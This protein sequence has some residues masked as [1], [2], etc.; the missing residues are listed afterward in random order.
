[1]PWVDD[2]LD[3]LQVQI[4]KLWY[5]LLRLLAVAGWTLQKGLFMMGHAIE[6]ANI[7]LV[8]NAFAPLITQTNNQMRVTAGL[9]FVIALIVL[10]VTY[11]LAAFVKLDVVS[12]RGAIGWYLAGIV[13]FQLGPL[14][15]QGMNDFRRDLSTGF[16]TVALD[17]MQSA[18]SPFSSLGAVTSSDLPPLEACDA[19]GPYLPGATGFSNDVDGLDIALAYLLADG[20]DVMGYPPPTLTSCFQPRGALY[21]PALPT[22]WQFYEDSYF[23]VAS[24]SQFFGD[25]LGEEERK[26]SIDKAGAAQFR[27]FSAWPM[28]IFG[29][30]EQLIFLLLTIA[31]GLTFVSFSIA[32]LFAF[33]KKT[34]V[35]ARSILDMWI[36]LIVQTVVIALM[37][38]LIISF[39]LGAAATQNALVVLGV[40]L[41]CTIFILVLLWSGIKAVWNSFN[42]L[43]GAI[44]QATGGVMVAPGAMGLGL[45]GA[46]VAAGV[47]ATA[48]AVNVGSSALAGTTAVQRGATTSQTAGVMLGGSRGLQ[49][50]ART[51]A[52]LPGT[53][54]TP[55]GQMADE[56]T[57]GSV[58]RQVGQSIPVVGGIAGPVIGAWML[59][60]R[61]QPP[62]PKRSVSLP[63]E[64]SDT[65]DAETTETRP[66][67]SRRMGTFTPL[68]DNVPPPAVVRPPAAAVGDPGEEIE[69]RVSDVGASVR[70]HAG[71]TRA[72]VDRVQHSADTQGEEVEER[73]SAVGSDVRAQAGQT[74][75]DAE[76]TAYASDMHGEEVEERIATL[77]AT[78]QTGQTQQVMGLMRVEGADNVAG[79][80]GDFISQ[81]RAQRTLDDQPMTGG[82][83]HFKVAQGVARAMGVTPQTDDRAPIQGDVS[84]LGL[85]GD[86]ALRL[87]LNGQQAQTVITEVKNS[88]TGELAQPTRTMLVEQARGTLNTG[89][90][91]AERAVSALQRAAVMLPN[92]ITARG[93]AAVPNI[94]VTPNVQVQVNTPGPASGGSLD[95]SMKSQAG[96]A[97]SQIVPPRGEA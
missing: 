97:G 95:D 55:I 75:A 90:E 91:G 81:M 92:A 34:E 39:L 14:L 94:T 83:D 24:S 62:K 40:S 17:S 60:D 28:V 59:S 20:Q 8:E 46:G 66:A 23:Y 4:D 43:F 61:S 87:G 25:P 10:G 65:D 31:Q 7:W 69:E 76:R 86:M 44:G 58:L 35:I 22:H 85:F 21:D 79:V 51:L 42:R 48:A 67:R 1:M 41:L 50:A 5:D 33:F 15:Y 56:F 84:R 47:G 11:M 3:G 73:V 18:G 80:M 38:S 16:Y 9:A 13:F 19:L 32:I 37:Q 52:Y 6:L 89:W 71:Q 96:L 36:E 26:E 64:P 68:S 57:E 93:T 29:V 70:S 45:A 30:V 63:A 77:G 74:R 78:L 88:P 54:N 72:A 53:R 2:V 82:A 49:S 27:I 12:P